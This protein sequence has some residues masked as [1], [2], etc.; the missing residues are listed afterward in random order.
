MP[1]EV[2]IEEDS[3]IPRTITGVPTGVAA[4]IGSAKKGS[5]NRPERI[6]SF[7]EFEQRFGGLAQDLQ[8]GYAV[9][10]FFANGGA[11]AV[12]VR[13]AKRASA[14]KVLAG[15]RALAA[16]DAFN[17]L[18]L[19]GITTPAIIAAAAEFCRGRRALLIVDPPVNVRTPAEMETFAQS[20]ALPR[21]RNAAIYFPWTKISDPLN[22]GHP[23]S[24]PPSGTIAGL[25]ARISDTVSVW[26][27]PAGPYAGLLGV[28]SLDYNLND[29]ESDPLNARAVNCLRTFPTFGIVAWGARTME[30]ANELAS[31][32]KYI[33]VRRLGLFIEESID[34]GTRWAVFEPND[35]PLWAQLRRSVADFLHALFRQGAFQGTTPQHAFYVRCDREMMT[36]ADIAKGILNIEIG[37]APLRPA[38]FVIIRIQQRAGAVE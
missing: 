1:P 3:A 23:R 4:F 26:K 11:E 38:E 13:I 37:F 5:V 20:S 36:D 16:V 6:A 14:A 35:E 12:V 2:F 9:R 32:W 7:A 34:R 33:A 8:L 30:G 15:I 25:I 10:Q 19:P 24:I 22:N 17:L 31:E 18:A 21:S 28:K 29:N 27:S